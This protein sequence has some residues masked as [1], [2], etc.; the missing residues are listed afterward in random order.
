M[1]ASC[2]I[3]LATLSPSMDESHVIDMY[4]KCNDTVPEVMQQ[5]AELYYEFFEEENISTAIRIGWC[6]SRGNHKAV[7]TSEGNNDTGVMQFVPWTW[8]WLA[9]MGYVPY[10]NTWVVMYRGRPYTKQEVS[11]TNVGFKMAQAQKTAYWNIKASSILAEEVYGKT[12]WRDWSSSQNCWENETKWH[13][14][15]KEEQYG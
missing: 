10:W 11:K 9:E 7:R 6:E 4:M 15:W 13:K 12:Q 2:I 3:F 8:N 14:L 1:I 5:H